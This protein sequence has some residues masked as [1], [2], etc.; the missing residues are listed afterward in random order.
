MVDCKLSLR[1][2]VD[3]GMVWEIAW[4]TQKKEKKRK[5]GSGRD[6]RL[7]GRLE[8]N[9][10]RMCK[11]DKQSF[12]DSK[13]DLLG[14]FSWEKGLWC[15]I[16]SRSFHFWHKGYDPG[17]KSCPQSRYERCINWWRLKS[18]IPGNS[19]ATLFFLKIFDRLD[20]SCPKLLSKS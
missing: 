4:Q 10:E 12:F 19:A 8:S 20:R 16:R 2:Y 5:A 13:L 11:I 3:E 14:G 17:L 1:L 6:P 9:N 18:G 7:C 15:W